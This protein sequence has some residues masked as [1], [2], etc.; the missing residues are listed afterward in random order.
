M[1]SHIKIA[2]FSALLFN[3]LAVIAAPIHYSNVIVFGD[4]LSDIGDMPESPEVISSSRGTIAQNIYVPIS[5]PIEVSANG[6]YTVPLSNMT[7]PYPRLVRDY[8]NYQ[9]ALK[10]GTYS[11]E[12]QHR[13]Y[14]SF[15]W[16][17]FFV[18]EAYQYQLI[19]TPTIT[20]W[21]LTQQ[22]NVNYEERGQISVD[23]AF[24]GAVSENSCYDPVYQNKNLDC[25][26]ADIYHGQKT[27]RDGN[28][29]FT[30]VEVPGFR[31]QVALFEDD[32]QKSTV[33]T[34]QNSLFLVMTGNNDLNKAMIAV[35]N[36]FND[37][38]EA[39]KE[40]NYVFK[41]GV[42]KNI[43]LGIQSLIDHGARHVVVIGSYDSGKTPYLMTNVWK[44]DP[45]ISQRV[46]N[47]IESAVTATAVDY[48]VQ[49]NLMIASLKRNNP[50]VDVRYFGIFSRMNRLHRQSNFSQSDTRYQACVTQL[51]TSELSAYIQ[52]DALQCTRNIN[53][54]DGGH[55][56][57][58][59]NGTHMTA[60]A[61]E[62]L[63]DQLYNSLIH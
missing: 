41:G 30:S 29:A 5:N 58:F 47:T 43:A 31:K 51:P 32:Q 63:A 49:L 15:N 8:Q 46:R 1:K 27:Y 38:I 10:L 17:L 6:S 45:T 39:I 57:M 48:N 37:P 4:S 2:F 44:G 55:D 34:D 59:W 23:Y 3:T 24:A 11:S 28:T 12:K 61:N 53:G 56:Y 60:K 54:S 14:H 16:P 35:N 33:V 19:D 36:M 52:G 25:A 40:L 62:Y 22:K 42:T 21:Y 13:V 7:L 50:G 26:A 18:N 20:P 9:P